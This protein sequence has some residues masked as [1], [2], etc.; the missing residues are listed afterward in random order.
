[1]IIKNLETV[2]PLF[3]YSRVREWFEKGFSKDGQR[4]KSCNGALTFPI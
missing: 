3:A 1:M 4:W 2:G